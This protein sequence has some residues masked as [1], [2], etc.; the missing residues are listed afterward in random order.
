MNNNRRRN[1]RSRPQ[2]NNFRRRSGTINSNGSNNLNINGNLSFN[3]N[4]SM[5]QDYHPR[6]V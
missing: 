6:L 4:G 5:V 3:R 1:Y 2:K